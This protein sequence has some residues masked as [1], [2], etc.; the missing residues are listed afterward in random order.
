[1]HNNEL[2]NVVGTSNP[3]EQENNNV[4]APGT[5]PNILV[6]PGLEQ[7][8]CNAMLPPML[9]DQFRRL[10]EDIRVNRLKV[11]IILSGGK[12][13]DG[14]QRYQ[15]CRE[16]GI[17]PRFEQFTGRNPLLECWSLNIA[18]RHLEKSQLAVLASEMTTRLM[19]AFRVEKEAESQAGRNQEN[20]GTNVTPV[21]AGDADAPED[22]GKK[23][24]KRKRGKTR[25]LVSEILNVSEGYIQKA[26]NLKEQDEDLYNKVREGKLTL[27]KAIAKAK[28]KLYRQRE[29]EGKDTSSVLVDPKEERFLLYNC[30]ILQAPIEDGSLDAIISDP[31]YTKETMGCWTQLAEFA[32]RKLKDGGILLAIAGNYHLQEIL[33]RMTVEGLNYFWTLCYHMPKA[34]T[35]V[36]NRPFRTN[37]KPILW[38]TKGEYKRT[39]QP[40]DVFTSDYADCDDGKQY[41]RWGQ[42]ALF[43]EDLVSKFTY[44]NELVCDPFIGGGTTGIAC[45]SQKRRF[46]GIDIDP[47][48]YKTSLDRLSKWKPEPITVELFPQ[49]QPQSLAA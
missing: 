49:N 38:Y 40:T 19:E 32:A 9:Q 17:E 29:A 28:G 34:G 23:R 41:H 47:V 46:V 20:G 2:E 22:N 5:L 12:V 7:H 4:T 27:P 31:P 37:W 6:P 16:L 18:R 39:F 44:A 10:K 13:L 42:S 48:S 33:Q 30:D 21:Q 35:P 1:M 14:W 25:S 36:N 3:T 8:E 11:P 15:I 43:F 24:T 45:L 26:K